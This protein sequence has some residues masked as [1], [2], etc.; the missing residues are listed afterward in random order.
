MSFYI[1]FWLNIHIITFILNIYEKF[2][3]KYYILT[4]KKKHKSS[5]KSPIP[6]MAFAIFNLFWIYR[7]L[8]WKKMHF[9]ETPSR[10]SRPYYCLNI[11]S[12]PINVRMYGAWLYILRFY[13][14]TQKV[15]T[16][17][18]CSLLLFIAKCLG[19]TM[20]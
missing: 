11:F 16:I 1:V 3:N 20:P 15:T 17:S 8:A 18:K 6:E 2:I 5:K 12:R 9:Y 19:V 4:Q 10:E 13:M 7:P 14:I